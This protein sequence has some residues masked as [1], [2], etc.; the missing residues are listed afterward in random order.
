MGSTYVSIQE[1]GFWIR[2][3][4][5]EL[6]LRLLALHVKDGDE[7][8]LPNRIRSQWLLASRGYF[9]GMVPDHLEEFVSS[10]EGVKLVA[11]AIESL[12]GALRRTTT[13]LHRGVL[14]VLGI[15]GDFTQDI[16]TKKLLQVTSAFRDLIAGRIS[17]N[18]GW[19]PPLDP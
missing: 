15:E 1:N 3:A 2:D 8:S 14:N 19:V 10:E 13:T 18:I 11:D 12:D 4:F 7:G 17:G 5:L 16:E 9:T 6:W